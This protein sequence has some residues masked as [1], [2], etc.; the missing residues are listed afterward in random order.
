[1]QH[2]HAAK[3]QALPHHLG[4]SG[5]TPPALCCASTAWCWLLLACQASSLATALLRYTT[6]NDSSGNGSSSHTF[7]KGAGDTSIC[8]LCV[9]MSAGV[10]KHLIASSSAPV[11]PD[12]Q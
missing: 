10:H 3:C 7:N 4:K 11:T 2:E 12:I 8:S 6:C 1:M 5:V 9:S